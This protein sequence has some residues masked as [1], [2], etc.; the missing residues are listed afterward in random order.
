MEVGALAAWLARPDDIYDREARWIGYFKTLE[1]FHRKM[2]DHF[3]STNPQL[4][5]ELE[6]CISAN[7]RLPETRFGRRI[8]PVKKPSLKDIVSDL[9]YSHVYAA[10][11]EVCEV[12]H[13]GPEMVV[14]HR[15]RHSVP[16]QH[17]LMAF[18]F[19]VH[20]ADEDWWIAFRVTGWGLAVSTYHSLR[21]FNFNNA[22]LQP[23]L[24][25][26]H[27]LNGR[28]DELRRARVE[29]RERETN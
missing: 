22:Q 13:G 21:N 25:A 1:S 4:A 6:D 7:M 23:I 17:Q 28:L 29:A 20:P 14:R 26:H 12:I 9:G 3:R 8:I 27:R 15:R 24:D 18:V 10:Y 19:G 11:R 16:G 2:A 5:K